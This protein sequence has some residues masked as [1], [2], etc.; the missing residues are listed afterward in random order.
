MNLGWKLAATIHGQAPEGLLDSYFAERHPI[1]VQVLDWSRAQ[2]AIMRPDAD[3]HALYGIVRDL[4]N[5]RDG[6]TYFAG[7][8]WGI[9][10]RYELGGSHPLVGCSVPNFAFE[11]GLTI[12]ELLRNGRGVLLDFSGNVSLGALAGDRLKYVAGRAKESLGLK[13]V[14][15][16]PDGIVA[17]AAD[18]EPDR[19]ELGK[20]TARWFA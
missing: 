19:G 14:L 12:G 11:D 1:G 15:V 16:R 3:A 6:A 7:R 20:T 8:V 10:T 17:W 9:F 4:L 5:T 18:G 2:V 13:A